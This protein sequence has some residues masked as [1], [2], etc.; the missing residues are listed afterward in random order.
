[1]VVLVLL[2]KPM[3]PICMA[4]SIAQGGK[5]EKPQTRMSAV[6]DLVLTLAR[7]QVVFQKTSSRKRFW[8]S[9]ACQR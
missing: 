1:M 8:S 6:F 4:G 3:M 5:N 2:G 9:L 7:N